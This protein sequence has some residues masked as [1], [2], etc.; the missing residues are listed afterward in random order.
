MGPWVFCP[1]LPPCACLLLS[2]WILRFLS[3]PVGSPPQPVGP[4]LKL[5]WM[6]QHEPHQQTPISLPPQPCRFPST[7]GALG[8]CTPFPTPAVDS[9]AGEPREQRLEAERQGSRRGS[10]APEASLPLSLRSREKLASHV[11][12]FAPARPYVHEWPPLDSCRPVCVRVC[13]FPFQPPPCVF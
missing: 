5:R 9:S 8:P 6:F 1:P 10:A 11:H 12:T 7:A 2:M 13:S 4:V 3:G